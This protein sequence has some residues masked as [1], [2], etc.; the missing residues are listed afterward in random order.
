MP[1]VKSGK[2]LTARQ[3][4]LIKRWIE[5]G[6]DWEPHWS[7]TPVQRPAVP[8][9]ANGAWVRSPID[10][11]VLARLEQGGLKPAPAAD[12]VTLI[13]RVTLDLTGLPPTPQE[14]DTFLA[15]TAAD[16]YER[17]VDRLLAS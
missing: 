15:D 4:E 7:F 2:T 9:V 14:V 13:R 3:K 11:F 6:M 16:A 1:P 5:Q 12:K 8:K 17:L 10:A